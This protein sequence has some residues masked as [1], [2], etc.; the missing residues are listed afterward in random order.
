MTKDVLIISS[1]SSVPA[2]SA[3]QSY[4]K[5]FPHMDF[6]QYQS[7]EPSA[8]QPIP[9]P[10]EK[11]Y[12]HQPVAAHLHSPLSISIPSS[13]L[14]HSHLPKTTT[15][16]VL[17]SSAFKAWEPTPRHVHRQ[18]S[19]PGH[20]SSSSSSST[21][22]SSTRRHGHSHQRQQSTENL[23][24]LFNQPYKGMYRG[25]GGGSGQGQQVQVQHPAQPS[26]HHHTRQ[27]SYSTHS[28]TEV[29]V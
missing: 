14:E 27:K 19:A 28:T 20:T 10:K 9:Q 2:H 21:V 11:S 4:Y 15:H 6:S 18:V 8:F 25:A 13:H 24:D 22:H 29:T 17:S 3:S 16:P 7:A 26:Y 1:S 12:I 5:S 23:P